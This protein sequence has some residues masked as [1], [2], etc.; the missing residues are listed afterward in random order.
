MKNEDKIT[1]LLAQVL[2]KVDQGDELIRRMDERIAQNKEQ[3]E[4]GREQIEQGKERMNNLD[5]ISRGVLT[6]LRDLA[7]RSGET[8]ELRDRIERL[9]KHTGL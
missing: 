5:E 8:D 9:E 2:R 6:L 7:K 3:I 1:E 4:Q